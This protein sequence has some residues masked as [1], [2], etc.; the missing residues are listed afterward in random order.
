MEV[1]DGASTNCLLLR[2][3]CCQDSA[4]VDSTGFVA[5]LTGLSAR[6]L[7]LLFHLIGLQAIDVLLPERD[8]VVVYIVV[9][10]RLMGS[11]HTI[12]LDVAI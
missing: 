7:L 2:L 8:L 1:G 4:D 12:V 9:D 10:S 3:S 11:S 6:V 5:S